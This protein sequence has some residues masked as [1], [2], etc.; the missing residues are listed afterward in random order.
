MCDHKS[1]VIKNY[2]FEQESISKVSNEVIDKVEIMHQ[3]YDET[4]LLFSECTINELI[5]NISSLLVTFNTLLNGVLS[6]CIINNLT[7]KLDINY[8][9]DKELLLKQ[10]KV[11]D[12]IKHILIGAKRDRFGVFNGDSEN[13]LIFFKECIIKNIH[14]V[15]ESWEDIRHSK[16][17]LLLSMC[18]YLLCFSKCNIQFNSKLY[19]DCLGIFSST[20]NFN[21]CNYTHDILE[22]I[23]NFLVRCGYNNCNIYNMSIYTYLSLVNLMTDVNQLSTIYTLYS[24]KS[25][26][27]VYSTNTGENIQSTLDIKNDTATKILNN[28]T[29]LNMLGLN[30]CLFVKILHII[31]YEDILIYKSSEFREDIVTKYP[32][33]HKFRVISACSSFVMNDDYKIFELRESNDLCYWYFELSDPETIFERLGVVIDKITGKVIESCVIPKNKKLIKGRIGE[34]SLIDSVNTWKE[35][36]IPFLFR[37]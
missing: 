33:L 6:R 18:N 14:I 15:G 5:L 30:V 35:I 21:Y 2:T 9:S 7:I 36:D 24:V 1:Y 11:D 26:I 3:K 32:E 34:N 16:N 13:T 23:N 20:V 25:N 29:L 4:Q 22:D 31:K 28:I 19:T 8:T 17:E 10:I 37:A 27:R 12:N